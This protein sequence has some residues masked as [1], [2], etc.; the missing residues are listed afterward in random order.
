MPRGPAAAAAVSRPIARSAIRR[1]VKRPPPPPFWLRCGPRA[2][3]SWKSTRLPARPPSACK[4]SVSTRLVR[5]LDG[6]ITAR[7]LPT[8]TRFAAAPSDN[9]YPAAVR[10]RD[11]AVWVAYVAY[12][13]GGEPDMAAAARGDFRTFFPT[14]NGDQI[15]LVKFDGKQFS[16]PLPVTEPLLDL[17][18][19]TVAVGGAGRVWIAWSQNV[20]GNW[21]IYRRNFDPAANQWSPIERVTSDP[22]AD[23][24]VVSTTDSTGT[25]GGPGRVAAGSIFR[26]S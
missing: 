9:D 15:R 18:K 14:G 7:R 13:R 21:D 19:P 26:S 6:Q 25:Y 22:G 4:T 23:I 20:G 12:Q 5:Y 3:R 17:W 10:G 2:K 16:A 1:H 24:N 11:G 8:A